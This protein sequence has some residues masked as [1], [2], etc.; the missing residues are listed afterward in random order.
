VCKG[1]KNT[2]NTVTKDD[3]GTGDRGEAKEWFNEKGIVITGAYIFLLPLL[4]L[5]KEQDLI[6]LN[7]KIH[8][9]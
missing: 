9:A 4:S 6:I 5:N 3:V 8:S 2:V 7:R 1:V